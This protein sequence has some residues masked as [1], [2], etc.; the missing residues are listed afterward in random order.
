MRGLVEQ[1]DYRRSMPIIF[2]PYHLDEYLA[3]LDVPVPPARDVTTVVTTLPE[4]DIWTRI[5]SLYEKVA[6]TAEAAVRAGGRPTVLSGDCATSLGVVAGLQHAGVDPAIVWFDAHGD[7]QTLET[8]ASGYV[9]GMPLRILVGYRPELISRR[10]RLRALPEHRAVLVG[11]RDLDPPEAEYLA[12][13]DIRRTDVAG[14]TADLLPDG[15]LVLHL[16]LDV[17]DPD[18]LPGL[19]FPAPGGPAATDVLAAARRVLDTGRVV[20]LS[21]GCTWRPGVPA[22]PSGAGARLLAALV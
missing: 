8:T 16:D 17:V 9:G 14:L 10:L 19:R 15:P 18:E 11:A 12:V 4:G 6:D 3:D 20:A 21:V 13:A 2:V 1:G 5:G 22:D 7:V